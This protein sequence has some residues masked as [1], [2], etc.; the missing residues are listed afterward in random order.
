MKFHEREEV[1]TSDGETSNEAGFGK[2]M[3]LQAVTLCA[4]PATR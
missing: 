4:H 1:Q 2:H 3:P